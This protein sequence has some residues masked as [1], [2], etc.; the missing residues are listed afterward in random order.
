MAKKIPTQVSSYQDR[1]STLKEL[2]YSSYQEYLN[3]DFWKSLRDRL[4]AFYKFKCRACRK[5]THTIHH[6]SYDR[7]TLLGVNTRF[8]V[9]LCGGCHLKVEFSIDGD[10]LT[11]KKAY[12]KY[13]KHIQIRKSIAKKVN[14]SKGRKRQKYLD[15]LKRTGQIKKMF[16]V[17]ESYKSSNSN[18]KKKNRRLR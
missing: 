15:W 16:E 9:P 10:K 18:A 2:G 11:L 3:S 1:N 5:P 13:K 8:L 4:L 14:S 12:V 6:V 17:L 7:D